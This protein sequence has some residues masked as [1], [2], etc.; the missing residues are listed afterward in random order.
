MTFILAVSI[1][2]SFTIR[3]QVSG[4][5]VNDIIENTEEQPAFPS[6]VQQEAPAAEAPATENPVN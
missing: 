3:N 1:I 4:V 6:A 5:D 2:T